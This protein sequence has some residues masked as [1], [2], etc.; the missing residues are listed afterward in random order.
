MTPQRRA[1]SPIV[2]HEE[3]KTGH[4]GN[5]YYI[6]TATEDADLPELE[7]FRPLID[8]TSRA[9]PVVLELAATYDAF[10]E[11]GSDHAGAIQRLRRK[12]GKRCDDGNEAAALDLLRDL[13][14]PT[15][16]G[17]AADPL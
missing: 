15:D 12:K 11:M 4:E 9:D 17:P 5:T 16:Q 1:H 13:E 3:E 14:L 8:R 7:P 6:L 2:V 10:R